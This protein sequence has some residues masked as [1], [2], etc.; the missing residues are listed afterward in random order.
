MTLMRDRVIDDALG[1]VP[2]DLPP[3]DTVGHLYPL[4]LR[5][6]LNFFSSDKKLVGEATDDPKVLFANR[7]RL[8]S[9]QATD[10]DV[11]WNPEG[12]QNRG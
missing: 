11:K 6:Q 2:E 12:N 8:R 5:P 4:T 3:I 1:C 9:W 7:S 10:L